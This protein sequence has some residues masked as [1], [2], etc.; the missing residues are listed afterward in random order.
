[1]AMTIMDFAHPTFFFFLQW[2][3]GV[4]TFCS[5]TVNLWGGGGVSL[6]AS[7]AVQ[8]SLMLAWTSCWTNGS[9]IWDAMTLIWRHWNVTLLYI[10]LI[11]NHFRRCC[12][13]LSKS[14]VLENIR[15]LWKT[16]FP[17]ISFYMAPVIF[18]CITGSVVQM[19]RLQFQTIYQKVRTGHA[20]NIDTSDAPS[21]FTKADAFMNN[22]LFSCEKNV[23]KG[24]HVTHIW[25]E[26]FVTYFCSN[27]HLLPNLSRTFN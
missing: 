4:A 18:T 25:G 27:D 19:V 8:F 24:A 21:S 5:I 10:P 6:R 7:D 15:N 26:T 3:H 20:G 9:V 14:L 12:G 16:S 13:L 22:S 17:W 2:C 23:N 11:A 1:M